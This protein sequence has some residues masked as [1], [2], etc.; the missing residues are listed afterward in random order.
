MIGGSAAS[1]EIL[2]SVKNKERNFGKDTQDTV[3]RHI[4]TV[5]HTNSTLVKHT[6]LFVCTLVK[7][8]Q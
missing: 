1:L 2:K 8:N 5:R 6:N 7:K 4:I 3:R